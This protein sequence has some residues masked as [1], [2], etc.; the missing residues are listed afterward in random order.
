MDVED[1][2]S[3]NSNVMVGYDVETNN[4]GEN[5]TKDNVFWNCEHLTTLS[6]NKEWQKLL[7]T[8]TSVSEALLKPDNRKRVTV[9][10]LGILSQVLQASAVELNFDTAA[11]TVTNLENVSVDATGNQLPF[12][13]IVF[14]NC[15]TDAVAAITETFRALRNSCVGEPKN[16]RAITEETVA[17]EE[18]CNILNILTSQQSNQNHVT[19]LRVGTQFL[20]NLVVNNK[21]TQPIIWNKCSSVLLSLLKHEDEK[22]AN[23]SSMVIYNILLGCPNISK[24]VE[25]YKEMLETLI[26]H[27]MKDS[28][29]AMFTIELLLS[30]EG[31]LPMMYGKLDNTHQLFLLEALHS[32]IS[33][34]STTQIPVSS[35]KFLSEQ[36]KVRSDCILKTCKTDVESLEPAEVSKQLQLLATASACSDYRSEL[37]SDKS[38]LIT[39]AML[40]RSIHSLGKLDEN[41]FSAI[42]KLASLSISDQNLDIL[43]HPAFG[44]KSS[45]VQ[46]LGNLCWKH[47]GNQNEVRELDCI[48]VL[49]DCCNIDARNPCILF[50]TRHRMIAPATAL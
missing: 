47:L 11:E 14:G 7:I 5:V 22:V 13:P 38:L 23:Y 26:D 19:C 6:K 8:L 24:A 46:I 12:R 18:T 44:F 34:D 3:S 25:D 50:V 36:F 16:Q 29:F 32:I 39:C 10:V 17:V 33:T 15:E 1:N 48:P 31:Y 35:V 9:E 45:L 42:Q 37:Q 28:E 43:E 41:H 21:E 4:D 49:L 27:A 30:K 2:M 20:G 40:L